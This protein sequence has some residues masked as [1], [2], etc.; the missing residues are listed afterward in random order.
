[1]K[2]YKKIIII[3]VIISVFMTSS[4]TAW[5]ELEPYDGVVEDGFWQTKEDVHATVIGC[6]SSLLNNELIERIILWGELRADMITTGTNANS[7]HVYITQ[8][9]IDSYNNICKWDRFYTT[10]NQCNKVI[11]KSPA[12]KD[13]DRTFS[14]NLYRQYIG[15]VTVIRSLMYFYLVRSFKDVPLVLKA[16]ESDSQ[17]FYIPKSEGSVILDTL[18]NQLNKIISPVSARPALPSSYG[19]NNLNKGRITIWAAMTLLADIYLWQGNYAACRDLCTQIIGSGQFSL[20]PVERDLVPVY[21]DVDEIVDYVY[22]VNTTDADALFEYI[23][24]TGNSVESIFE[25]QFP[26]TSP[27]LA[28]QFYDLFNSASNRPKLRAKT[29]ILDGI[30]F[31]VYEG[32][33]RDVYDIRANNFSYKSSSGDVWK[34]IGMTRMGT[35]RRNIREFPHWILYRLPDVMLMK[36]EALCMLGLKSGDN[37]NMYDEAYDLVKE[38]RD[39]SNAVPTSDADLSSPINGKELERLIL[40]ERAREFAFEG[41]RWYDVLR[42]VSRDNFANRAYLN[43]LAIYSTT[44]EKVAS[45]QTKY[46]NNWFLY[47]PIYNNAIETNPNLVQNEF[48]SQSK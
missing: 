33:D 39:R 27:V 10:I 9:E 18:V 14:E 23:Y 2:G 41:K 11:E 17:D 48:Y 45:L 47:W 1:M 42:Y 15:E 25:F 21:N 19:N 35:A 36:A 16:T 13:L 6:Y 43:E 8:G 24:V 26:K 38:I 12:V 31:P 28:D 22:H 37:Q 34:Y 32:S 5:L 44:P 40:M 46:N 7:S 4:C 3:T 20:I 30:I 29:D